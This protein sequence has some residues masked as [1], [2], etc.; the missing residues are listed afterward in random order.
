MTAKAL[1]QSVQPAQPWRYKS[2]NIEGLRTNS[3]Q[4]NRHS[5]VIK[6]SY[7]SH[8]KIDYCILLYIS[9]GHHG[10]IFQQLISNPITNLKTSGQSCPNNTKCHDNWGGF[11]PPTSSQESSAAGVASTSLSPT[12]LPPCSARPSSTLEGQDRVRLDSLQNGCA[13][14]WWLQDGRTP[15]QCML[16]SLQ[17]LV[18]QLLY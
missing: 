6:D 2:S 11:Q 10:P 5:E 15:N 9:T 1:A 4:H 12:S 18:F 3:C 8:N 7:Q 14:G 17:L 16:L 13:S